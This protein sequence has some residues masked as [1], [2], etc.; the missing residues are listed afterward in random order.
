MPLHIV[1]KP[2][3]QTLR[4]R[5]TKHQLWADHKD[6]RRQALEQT[7]NA[8]AANQLAEDGHTIDAGLEVGVLDARLD[9]I[10]RGSDGDGCDG[11]G[12]GSEEILCPGGAC[13]VLDT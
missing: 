3:Y 2:R 12:D 6:L 10:E 4:N 7:P 13:V 1:C 8:L 9:D 5:I 11:P